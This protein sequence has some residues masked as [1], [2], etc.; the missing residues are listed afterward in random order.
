MAEGANRIGVPETVIAPPGMSIWE[1]M[2]YWD[3][4]LAV[5]IWE[6]IVRIGRF[7]VPAIRFCVLV[8]TAMSGWVM[9][10]VVMI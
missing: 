7:V 1:P 9:G 10:D 4:V 8:A 6:P 2:M 3:A 5:T